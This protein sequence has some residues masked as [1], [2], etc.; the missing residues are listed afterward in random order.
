MTEK[1]G[2]RLSQVMKTN[3]P[4]CV[5]IDPHPYLIESWGLQDTPAGLEKFSLTT[6]EAFVEASDTIAAIKPQVALFE[7]FGSAGFAV[8]ERILA[9]ASEANLLTI[10]DAKRGDIGSTM[11]G[12][13]EA[14]LTDGSL[15]AS[16]AVTLSPYL[17][18]ESLRPAIDLARKN[19][20]GVFVLGLTS[21]PEGASIQHTGGAGASVAGDIINR[22][23]ADNEQESHD[24]GSIGLVI[25]ATV[26]QQAR[27]LEIDLAATRAPLLAPGYGSQGATAQDLKNGFKNAWPQVLVNTSRAVL[28][29][30]PSVSDLVRAMGAAQADL[31]S[32]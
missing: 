27:E 11:E 17:G 20:R 18:Y 6:L 30:G 28:H 25:G 2:Q 4:L 22:V 32:A 9:E 13:A 7:R 12:Y 3:G 1:F 8:L 5:G 24:L 10:S 14:W 23:T 21:N 16:D 26:A 31:F 15:L 19:N 29:A